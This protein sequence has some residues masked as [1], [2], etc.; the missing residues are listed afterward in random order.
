MGF[1]ILKTLK[2]KVSVFRDVTSCIRDNGYSIS[3]ECTATIFKSS[4]NN[5]FIVDVE[6]VGSSETLATID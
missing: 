6:V 3:K 2:S 5:D 1:E 4:G